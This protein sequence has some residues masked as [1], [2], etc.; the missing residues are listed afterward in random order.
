MKRGTKYMVNVRLLQLPVTIRG[1]V[2]ENEDGTYTIVLNSRLSY[3]QNL[4][5]YKHEL[6]HIANNDFQKHDVNEAERRFLK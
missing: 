3:E 2:K 6:S 1:F 4:K 5:T